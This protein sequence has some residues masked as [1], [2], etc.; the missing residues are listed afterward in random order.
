MKLV[1]EVRAHRTR[2]LK[3]VCQGLCT[4]MH[5]MHT[6]STGPA[7]QALGL[8]IDSDFAIASLVITVEALGY[9]IGSLACEFLLFYYCDSK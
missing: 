8:L 7:L 5:G 3:T 6:G 2:F 9:L 1:R 4:M